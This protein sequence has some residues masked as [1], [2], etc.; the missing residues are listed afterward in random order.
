LIE[1]SVVVGYAQA[2]FEVADENGVAGDVEKDL[3]GIKEL[4]R[5]NKK[6]RAVLYHP[7]ITKTEKKT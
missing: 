5:T 2:L 6:F 7:A 1:E 4:L 3:E